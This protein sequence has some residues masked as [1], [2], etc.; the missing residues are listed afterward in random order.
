MKSLLKITVAIIGLVVLVSCGSDKTKREL[1][2]MPDMYR[3]VPYEAYS[4]NPNFKNGL[5]SQLPVE[6]TIARGQVP[7]EFP[8]TN[9]GYEAA[10]LTLQSPLDSLTVN[11]EKGKKLYGIYC[12]ICHGKKGDGQS[13][14]AEREKFEGVPNYKDRAITDGSIY[15]VIMKGKGLMGSHASQLRDEERWQV[16]HYVQQLKTDLTK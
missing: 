6:G 5:S 9:E 8:D 15:H 3:P 14:L 10:K 13:I 12:A 1:Q 2:Y 7:Y 4:T 11:T 16:V